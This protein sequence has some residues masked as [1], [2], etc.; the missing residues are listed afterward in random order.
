MSLGDDLLGHRAER[1][2]LRDVVDLAQ[3][4]MAP[5]AGQRDRDPDTGHS[6]T[7]PVVGVEPLALTQRFESMHMYLPFAHA[8][9]QGSRADQQ[10]HGRDLGP[11]K[12]EVCPLVQAPG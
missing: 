12:P 4:D 2:A 6:A 3:Q 9:R 7:L 1:D 5:T 8:E 10:R 11:P